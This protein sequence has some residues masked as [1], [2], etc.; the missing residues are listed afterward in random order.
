MKK[1]Q[2][3]IISL[4]STI[5][6]LIVGLFILPPIFLDEYQIRDTIPII[7]LFGPYIIFGFTY[8]AQN[9]M[10]HRRQQKNIQWFFEKFQNFTNTT[11]DT[12]LQ[13]QKFLSITHFL[14]IYEREF[15]RYLDFRII[16]LENSENQEIFLINEQYW[17]KYSIQKGLQIQTT[18][19]ECQSYHVL[20]NLNE[21]YENII[22]YCK[23]RFGIHLKIISK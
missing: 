17:I 5:I 15:G 21:M 20:T 9:I 3:L 2:K 18:D 6:V 23:S 4:V 22:N 12:P 19:D 1:Y 11:F 7:A 13:K 16:N 14:T 10:Q 8:W